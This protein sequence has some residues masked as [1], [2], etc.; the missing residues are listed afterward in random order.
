MIPIRKILCPV[1]TSDF[2]RRAVQHAA[3]LGTWYEAE[4]TVLYVRPVMV[5]PALW[6]GAPPV[7]P[8]DADEREEAMAAIGSF[9][10]AA[11]GDERVS[12]A[13][14]EGPVVEEILRTAGELPADLLVMG[15]HGLS[16][17]ERLLLG[18]ITEKTL[19]KA[20]C[21]VLTVPRLAAEQAAPPH[22][23]FATIVCGVDRSP[24][25]QRALRYALSLAQEA[26]GRLVLVHTIEDLSEE[27]P[28]YSSHFNTPECWNRIAPEIRADY[29]KLVP[30][31][32]RVWCDLEVVV[33]HGKAYREL[34]T[35]AGERRADLIVVGAAGSSM[36]FG[37]TVQ[38]VLRQ[39]ACP[40]LAVPVSPRTA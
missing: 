7:L 35:V 29:E 20:P 12:I 2:S 40:V 33:P 27:D 3:A 38:H 26:G 23:T 17:F 28:R 19:R 34:L 8:P 5:T 4:V 32:A 31:D 11:V 10:K 13:V 24:A 21:P 9:V 1:D 6:F 16:G 22:V 39:A 14:T 18:S 25:S 37:T 36:P 30:A 15:T